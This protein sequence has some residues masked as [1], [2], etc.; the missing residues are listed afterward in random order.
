MQSKRSFLWPILV[1]VIGAFFLFVALPDSW[2]AWAPGFLRSPTIHFGLDL[3]GGTQLDFRISE[4]EMDDQMKR[5]QAEID[6]LKNQ[7]AD[8]QKIAILE[9]QLRSTEQQKTTI[10]ESIRTVLERRINALGVSEAVITPS[11]MGT[12]KHLLVE[13]PGVVDMQ[14]CIATVGKTIQL[15]FKEEFTE[16]TAEFEKSV[17][18]RADAALRRITVSGSTLSVVG[19][20][21]G[22]TLGV[23]YTDKQWLIKSALPKGLEGVWNQKPGVVVK[24]EGSVMVPDQDQNG[25]PI[26]KPVS[27][28][29]LTEV[30]EPKTQ[31]GHTV[32]EAPTAF[33]LLAE[34]KK[35]R[36]YIPM[37]DTVLDDKVDASI[38]STILAMG[39]GELKI[40]NLA[41]GSAALIF[42]RG[43]TPG[44]EQMAASHILISYAGATGAAKTVTRTKDQA[45]T[46]VRKLKQDIDGGASFA[47][48]AKKYSDDTG[49]ASKGGSLGTFGRNAMV[50]AFEEAAFALPTGGVSDPVETQFGYHL[51]RADQAVTKAA[52]RAAFDELLITG[53]GAVVEAGGV[54]ADLKAGRVKK[55]EDSIALRSLFFSLLPTGW[56][57]TTLN[58]KHFR[59]AGVTLDPTSSLPIVQIS[60]DEEGAKLFQELT[61]KNVGKRI[62]IF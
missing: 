45:L 1:A 15:E 58:G 25:N 53:T 33:S 46:T 38:K 42:L 16:A 61:K 28:I 54:L 11:Y 9:Q 62:A 43:N 31:T 48:L 2:K 14:K 21:L 47:E 60:F 40:A 39:A 20:D 4:Q 37:L 52:D 8:S 24:R 56:K 44:Q 34:G 59:S 13:C 41:D 23:A 55:F 27:G 35:N 51:I 32:N 10:V 12:E 18:D 22:S 49:N 50:P 36:S 6:Q 19:Q 17:H 3:V 7:N 57:D 26:E 29:F 5:I 30:T